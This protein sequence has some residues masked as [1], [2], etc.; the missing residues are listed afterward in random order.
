MK[1]RT[2]ILIIVGVLAIVLGYFGYKAVNLILYNFS[3]EDIVDL[4]IEETINLN[5]NKELKS[6]EEYLEFKNIKIRNDFKDFKYREDI[7]TNSDLKYVLYDE[8]EELKASFWVGIVDSY[9]TNLKNA[10]T[11]FDNEKAAYLSDKDLKNLR[12]FL[13]ENNINDDIDLFKYLIEHKDDKLNIFTS[14][15]KM[16]E[17]YVFYYLNYIMLAGD[18]D[19]TLIDGTFSGYILELNNGTKQ[20]CILDDDKCYTFTF[21]GEDYF[22]DNYISELLSTIVIDDNKK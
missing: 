21:I 12:K 18:L 14:V 9:V 10:E 1:R 19:I 13:E 15:K 8:F 11:V 6:N 22:T 5:Y 7:S 4:E 3:L 16:R 17:R 2:K 20:T